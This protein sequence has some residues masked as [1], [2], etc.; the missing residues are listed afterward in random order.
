MLATVDKWDCA[1]WT[2]DE[3]EFGKVC[4]V[5]AA[6][7]IEVKAHVIQCAVSCASKQS[8]ALPIE[9]LHAQVPR[10]APCTHVPWLRWLASSLHAQ[11]PCA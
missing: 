7:A 11:A 5:A 6:E 2:A 9:L 4:C 3:T 1:L 8:E 10:A